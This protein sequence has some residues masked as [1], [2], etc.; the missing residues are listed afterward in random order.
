VK[1]LPLAAPR[2]GPERNRGPEPLSQRPQRHPGIGGAEPHEFERFNPKARHFI[3]SELEHGEA[4]LSRRNKILLPGIPG[5]QKIHPHQ[6]KRILCRSRQSEMSLMYGVES[7]A[8][9]SDSA[10]YHNPMLP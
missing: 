2:N 6:L 4:H 7:A 5:R 3:Q 1:V 9:K 10:G 8:E